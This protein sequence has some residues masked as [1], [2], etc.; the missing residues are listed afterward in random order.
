MEN[1]AKAVLPVFNKV[2]S[3]VVDN[4]DFLLPL[5]TVLV[6]RMKAMK[7]IQNVTQ[8]FSAA[9]KAIASAAAATSAESLATAVST[10][11][12]TLKQAAVG[13]LTGQIGLVT[14]AQ[15]LWNTVMSANPIGAIIT[16]IGLLVIALT[17]LT[18][19]INDNKIGTEQLSEA[20]NGLGDSFGEVIE[21]ATDFQEGI[22]NAESKLDEF[23]DTMFASSEEQEALQS[24]ME[25]IQNGIT[26]ICKTASDERRDYTDQEIEQLNTYFDRMREIADQQLAIQE[27]KSEAIKQQAITEAQAFQGSLE[28]YKITAQE[29]LNTAQEQADQQIALIEEQTTNELALL[30]QRYGDQAVLSNEAYKQEYDELMARKQEKIDLANSEIAAVSEAYQNGY[31]ERSGSL[32]EF[33]KTTQG[34]RAQEEINEQAHQEKLAEIDAQIAENMDKDMNKVREL[35]I[36]REDEEQAHASELANIKNKYNEAMTDEVKAELGNWLAMLSQTELYGGKISAENKE[37]VDEFLEVYEGMDEDGKKTMDELMNGMLGGLEEQEPSLF[38][39]AKSIA[40]SV[41]GTFNNI[42]GIASPSKV[43]KKMFGYL[44]EGGEIGL[45]K[46]APALVKTAGKISD[47][48]LNQFDNIDIGANIAKLR[49]LSAGN[50]AQLTGATIAGGVLSASYTISGQEETAESTGN[51]VV[52]NIVFEQPMQAPDEIARAL[53]IQQT[54][55]LAGAR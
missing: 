50:A 53:R 14:A 35:Q 29:W 15:A 39:K 22:Q 36:R 46:A 17:G 27:A 9:S 43:M 12:I 51:H 47:E 32:Q 38:A 10:K 26:S 16:T 2:F 20:Y 48:V 23:N 3:F 41:I 45:E 5:V 21:S 49:N 24:N 34:L 13:V 11:A 8:W 18:G 40:D 31:L 6:A 19:F 25:E 33:F 7:V 1:L 42:F 30:N 55:G 4:F 52:Q 28:E 54:Y 44:M 37:F